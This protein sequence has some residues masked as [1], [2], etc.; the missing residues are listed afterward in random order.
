M[1]NDICEQFEQYYTGMDEVLRNRL[2]PCSKEITVGLLNN[3]IEIVG[4]EINVKGL[5]TLHDYAS[6]LLNHYPAFPYWTFVQCLKR[7][8][9]F[10][11]KLD[12]YDLT[13]V[14]AA[15]RMGGLMTTSKV[16]AEKKNEILRDSIELGRLFEQIEK[17]TNGN[18]MTN[19]YGKFGYEITNPIPVYGHDG[20]KDYFLGL[21][22]IDNR[23]FTV[24][25][26]GSVAAENIKSII[27]SYTLKFME[28]DEVVLYMCLYNTKS[29]SLTPEG[30]D[31]CV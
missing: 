6:L 26:N 25:R 13:L 20:I 28:G 5:L 23:Q 7:R 15:A 17:N 11:E 10:Y 22:S 16:D 24:T 27:D 18:Y 9:M 29:S 1:D 31:W 8:D 19:S 21:C 2:Y 30:F 4:M 12:K 14:M 3:L